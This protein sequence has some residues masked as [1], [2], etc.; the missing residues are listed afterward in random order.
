VASFK[1]TQE[2]NKLVGPEKIIPKITLIFSTSS[3]AITAEKARVR[4]KQRKASLHSK[5]IT[6]SWLNN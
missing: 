1:P 4:S 6:R 2:K 3:A 5:T